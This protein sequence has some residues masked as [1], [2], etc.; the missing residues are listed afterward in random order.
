ME[1]NIYSPVNI[2][3]SHLSHWIDNLVHPLII[4]GPCSAESEEQV[5]QTAH[6]LAKEKA[7]RIFR[8]GIWKPRTRPGGFAGVGEK[9]LSWLTKVKEQT[10][11]LTAVEVANKEHVTLAVSY[12]IDVLWVGAR[13][14]ANPFAIEEISDALAESNVPVI[15]KNPINADL[16]LWIG[17]IER[18]A[19]KGISKLIAVHRGFSSY[20]KSKY[21]HHPFWRI[22][23]E[24][25]ELLPQIPLL[26][27]PSHIAGKRNF[28]T[29]ICQKAMDKGMDG[30][31]IE[32]HY[33]PES[34]LSDSQQQITPIKLKEIL[35]HLVY[36]K[37]FGEDGNFTQKL[38]TLREKIDLV[39]REIIDAL[40]MRMDIVDEIGREKQQKKITAFQLSRLQ[41]L[42]EERI[43]MG[44]KVNLSPKYIREV[45]QII[46]EESVKR[47]STL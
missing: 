22:P 16:P 5:L 31:M 11:L 35:K 10:G 4:A 33:R 1:Q 24:L 19:M 7:V 17:A 26:C 46:H 20:E 9:G 32:T 3:I 47:Q 41:K 39:D 44:Q 2:K 23:M 42:M 18:F 34:A 37:E 28:I 38:Q 27:D 21:R 25:K 45:F 40:Q 13:T 15:I 30:L 8:A 29:E 12:G 6:L 36:K 14:T 43:K